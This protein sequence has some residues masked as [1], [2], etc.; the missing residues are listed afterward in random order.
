VLYLG[1]IDNRVEDFDQR[2]NAATQHDLR[3]A[4]DAVLAGR[5][6]PHAS[7]KVVGC[8]IPRIE[9]TKKGKP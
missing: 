3:N 2:R 7:A 6:A 5:P 9:M 1:R 8:A 4:L